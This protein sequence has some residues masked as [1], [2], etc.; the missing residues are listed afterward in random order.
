[1]NII[2]LINKE[3]VGSTIMVYHYVSEEFADS[4]DNL[5]YR[6]ERHNPSWEEE[7]DLVEVIELEV[8]EVDTQEFSPEVIISGEHNGKTLYVKNDL[9]QTITKL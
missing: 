5:L 4:E 9:Y 7:Y 2:E 6:T 3:L 1:M 8:L